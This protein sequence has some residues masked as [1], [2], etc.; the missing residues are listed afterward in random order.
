M[1]KR[2]IMLGAKKRN[3][4]LYYITLIYFWNFSFRWLLGSLVEKCVVLHVS[5]CCTAAL[6][7]RLNN[8]CGVVFC[9]KNLIP[10]TWFPCTVWSCWENA[11]IHA[12]ISRTELKKLPKCGSFDL[13]GPIIYKRLLFNS[14]K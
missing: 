12:T 10:L 6:F 9:N 2:V 7:L 14:N 1:I 4:S 3:R 13:S 5:R 11:R 8:K